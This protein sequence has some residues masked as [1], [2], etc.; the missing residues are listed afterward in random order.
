[1]G[2]RN[3]LIEKSWGTMFGSL[4]DEKAGQLIK[5]MYRY[6]SG[7]DVEIEDPVLLAVFDMVKEKMDEHARSYEAECEKRRD[8]VNKRWGKQE[9]TSESASM[10][11]DTNVYKCIQSDSDTSHIHNHNHNQKHNHSQGKGGLGEKGEPPAEIVEVVEHLNSV[12][13]THFRATTAGTKK[14]INARLAEG[15]TVDDCKAVIDKKARDWIGTEW[16]KYLQPSTLFNSEKFEN[17]LNQ[18]GKN[19]SSDPLEGIT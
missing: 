6:E 12:C 5:A 13:G 8:N 4:P 10:Q 16:E 11:S 9:R 1:M 15:F 3:F 7:E 18:K 2:K 17:Y 19:K 14:H